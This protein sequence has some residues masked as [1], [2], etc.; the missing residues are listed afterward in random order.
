M[1]IWYKKNNFKSDYLDICELYT[2]FNKLY[3]ISLFQCLL[4]ICGYKEQYLSIEAFFKYNNLKNYFPSKD[5]DPTLKLAIIRLNEY[6]DENYKDKK[7]DKLKIFKG[8]DTNK[9]GILSSEEFIT[10]LNSLKG[11]NLNDSQKYKLY[12]F[13]DT[14]K[15]GKINAK[16]FLELIKSIKNYINEE[17]ELNAP[18]PAS[19]IASID[20]QK[21]I[22]KILKKEISI[23]KQNYKHNKTKIKNLDKNAF[24]S[25]VVKLQGD[26][27]NNYFNEECMENDF[28]TADKKNDGYVSEKI[29][30]IILQKR[31]FS[32]DNEIYNLFIKFT[33][34]DEEESNYNDEKSSNEYDNDIDSKNKNKK[35]N[36]KIFLNKLASYKIK[37]NKDGKKKDALPKIK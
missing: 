2:I 14:N 12:N 13:A 7:Q 11:L 9:D 1:K 21:Y 4:I 17:G 23:I 20:N 26:L 8:Y 35:I 19:S 15:D 37:D 27:I 5:F 10:A 34:E 22:P 24:L 32:V 28:I 6:I 16:E 31:L 36:Y 25:C 18:I 3:N 33:E 30:K 29:F